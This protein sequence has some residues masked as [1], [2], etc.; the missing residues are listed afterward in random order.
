MALLAS[1]FVVT[2]GGTEERSCTLI[3][4]LSGAWLRIQALSSPAGLAGATVTV[5]RNDQCRTA[6][7]PPAP[8]SSGVGANVQFPGTDAVVG[9]LWW[10]ESGTVDLD[11]EWREPGEVQDGDHFV[12]TLMDIAG[13]VST[14]LDKYATYHR[15]APNGEDCAPVCWIAELSS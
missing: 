11:L 10:D 7:L 1:L 13:N 4:C 3:G 5:C 14:L 12:V 8:A 15:V 2:C 6:P 9:T